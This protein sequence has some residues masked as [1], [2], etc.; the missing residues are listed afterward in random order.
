MAIAVAGRTE[1]GDSFLFIDEE[2]ILNE[3]M[4]MGILQD[5]LFEEVAYVSELSIVSTVE[6]N[7]DKLRE[8][9]SNVVARCEELQG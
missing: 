1:S 3:E 8:I 5:E 7:Q 4:I 9:A 6:F 2:D